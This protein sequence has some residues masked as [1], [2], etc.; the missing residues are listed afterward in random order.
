MKVYC[1]KCGQKYDINESM[2]DTE[3]DCHACQYVMT[4]H[5]PKKTSE[6]KTSKDK[7]VE[8]LE[9]DL[10]E[11]SDI[12]EEDANK[13]SPKL[14]QSSNTN[15][16]YVNSLSPPSKN[17]SKAAPAFL[18]LVIICLLGIAYLQQRNKQDNQDNVAA[19]KDLPS[20]PTVET[21]DEPLPTT[22]KK[23]DDKDPS[24]E[25]PTVASAILTNEVIPDITSVRNERG[26]LLISNFEDVVKPFAE[27]H[28][29]S[30]HG[31]EKEKG[32]FRMDKLMNTGLIKTE[33]DAE[34]WQEVLDM[35]NTGEMPPIEEKQP[36]KPE[37]ISMLDALYKT[38]ANARDIIASKG[39]GVMRRL[40]SREY[41]NVIKDIL[42]LT[43]PEGSIPLDRGIDGFDTL[44]IDLSTTPAELQSYIDV[45]H[46]LMQKLTYDYAT[47]A[48]IP[49][50]SRSIFGALSRDP[51]NSQ[52]QALFQRFVVKL[53]RHQPVPSSMINDMTTL[54]RY[55][56]RKGA[57]FWEA[58]SISLTCA[59]ASPNL[60]YIVERETELD[61]LDIANR[62]SLLL[63]SSVPDKT[64]IDLA[65]K[66][67]LTKPEIYAQQ[68]ERMIQD[69]KAERF[70]DTFTNQ[71][72]ELH[73][74]EVVNIDE[75]LF[76]ELKEQEDSLK[77]HMTKQTQLF[78]RQLILENKPAREMVNAGY[79]MLNAP[80]AKHYGIE[81]SDI[82]ENHFTKVN[83][84]GKDQVR[85]GILGQGAIQMLTS[86]GSRTSPVERGVFI[87][88]KLLDS[89]PPP[90]PA[91]VPE[92]E[93]V[94]G[95]DQTTR[96]LLKHHMTTAQ[97]A[98][99]HAKID[100]LGFGMESFGPLGRWR[101]HE[102][103]LPID[104]SGQMINGRQFDG[105]E[106]L[107]SSLAANDER[108]AKGFV[109]A[110]MS[111]AIGRKVRYTDSGEIQNIIQLSK[112]NQFK[113][114]DLI[115][116][117]TKSK[118]FQTKR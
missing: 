35:I 38:T 60:I 11:E 4:F 21:T 14:L 23:S 59:L 65:R 46:A 31:P 89:S 87:L 5:A 29:I 112:E 52:V 94:T 82:E 90:A 41:A 117:V 55:N 88:R 114:K 40:N 9:E 75:E 116:Q 77:E 10:E 64:L 33:A 104:A 28:C 68:F 73:R 105:F 30:C 92:A 93:D 111:Y 20:Q 32:D 48:E 108:I 71:W 51:T 80:L 16:R 85:G 97:C 76:P 110:I 37:V 39:N 2:F 26:N 63:W 7:V 57:T 44:G 22:T 50:E 43:V 47:G 74:L 3:I 98:A 102:G 81:A 113:L 6:K 69:P 62:L 18:T 25:E 95:E 118:T 86:N 66:G 78:M 36:S 115:F 12:E 109:K 1:K 101:N 58:T 8:D 100:P 107:V 61:Q 42:G 17:K 83:L 72:L 106:G 49:K 24:T 13:V 103:D 67:E 19:P 70:F 96:E 56:R 54:F 27:Q 15:P 91:N 84:E 34:H 79:T 53:Y 45:S 99:C